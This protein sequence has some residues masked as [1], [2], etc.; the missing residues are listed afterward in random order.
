[1]PSYRPHYEMPL[2]QIE[3]KKEVSDY[4][5]SDSDRDLGLVIDTDGEED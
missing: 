4:E 1:M 3:I 5:R 2:D